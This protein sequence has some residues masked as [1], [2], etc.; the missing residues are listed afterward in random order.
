VAHLLARLHLLGYVE[1]E[2]IH[3]IYLLV[4][5]IA[6]LEG[7]VEVT[8]FAPLP[9]ALR[10]AALIGPGASGWCGIP[11]AGAPIQRCLGTR[12]R[13]PAAAGP[14]APGPPTLLIAGVDELIHEIRALEQAHGDRCL[15]YELV[16]ALPFP[17]GF[18]PGFLFAAWRLHLFGYINRTV[19]NVAQLA[20][21]VKHG[22]IARQ[23]VAFHEVPRPFGVE[24][25]IVL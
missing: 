10:V 20:L 13:L 12:A 7:V 5:I 1:G 22:R 4:F 16:E 25:V 3:A 18:E 23:P 19:N 24:H 9:A 15:Q 8:S 14:V 2:H 21:V 11:V 17:L 6:G